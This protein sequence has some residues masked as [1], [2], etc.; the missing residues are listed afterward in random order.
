[1]K[2]FENEG[3]VFSEVLID[4]TFPHEMLYTQASNRVIN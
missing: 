3:V 1:M 4:K 2:A